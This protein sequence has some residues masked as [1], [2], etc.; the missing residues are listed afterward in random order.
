MKKKNLNIYLLIGFSL[1]LLNQLD[2]LKKTYFVFT[3]KYD[4]RF[5]KAYEA[6]YFSGF[7]EKESH[8]YIHYIKQKFNSNFPPKIINFEKKKR[9][10]PYWIFY[11]PYN[12]I[13]ENELILLS[14]NDE[15]QF[16]FDNYFILDAHNN[17]CFY[18]KKK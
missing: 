7:C 11:K 18:L 4:L 10:L 13:N 14:Y 15:I 17:K 16:D 8:G 6:D 12:N 9:K 1:I 2:L 5:K 3:S